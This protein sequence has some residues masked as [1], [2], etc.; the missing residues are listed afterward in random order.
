MRYLFLT[1]FAIVLMYFSA[2]NNSTE[3]EI[4]LIIKEEFS[5]YPRPRLPIIA[6]NNKVC[7][8]NGGFK[9]YLMYSIEN[10]EP[11][12]LLD[13][14]SFPLSDMYKSLVDIHSKTYPLTAFDS[15]YKN[16]DTYLRKLSSEGLFKS[17]QGKLYTIIKLPYQ[18]EDPDYILEGVKYKATITNYTHFLAY[19][20]DNLMVED[21][22]LI[23]DRLLPDQLACYFPSQLI[24]NEKSLIVPLIMQPGTF[25][26]YQDDIPAYVR[27]ELEIGRA[28]V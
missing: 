6:D 27:L 21:W 1:T 3:K 9:N 16:P 24:L 18:Y 5:I 8:Y 23:D 20:S 7:F 10:G 22:F 26:Q 14:N 4:Q 25:K 19:L 28:H 15:L 13:L 2:C 12:K 17:V 11:D